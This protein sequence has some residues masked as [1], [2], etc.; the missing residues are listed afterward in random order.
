MSS[1]RAKN[2]KVVPFFFCSNPL[3]TSLALY[4]DFSFSHKTQRQIKG[5]TSLG[6]SVKIRFDNQ[7][8]QNDI[9][10]QNFRMDFP[11]QIHHLS[12][13]F[14]M[15]LHFQTRQFQNYHIQNFHPKFLAL[16]RF[17]HYYQSTTLLIQRIFQYQSCHGISHCL[18][19]KCLSG[20]QHKLWNLENLY[21]SQWIFLSSTFF[22]SYLFGD[23]RSIHNIRIRRFWFYW[24]SFSDRTINQLG[25]FLLL[26][27]FNYGSNF[28]LYATIL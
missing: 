28:L 20:F 23:P 5:S 26:R 4:F 9:H 12:Q 7:N 21:P 22:Q 18:S 19:L 1:N 11:L 17:E 14:Q 10:F 27:C 25:L 15:S 2:F 13:G 16:Q 24:H 3:T 8:Y 6:F